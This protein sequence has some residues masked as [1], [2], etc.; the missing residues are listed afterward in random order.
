MNYRCSANYFYVFNKPITSSMND[1]NEFYFQ[2]MG[3]AFSRKFIYPDIRDLNKA[4]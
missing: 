3:F 4:M 2:Q 1:T